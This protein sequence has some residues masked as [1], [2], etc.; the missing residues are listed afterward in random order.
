MTSI[1]W[2][3]TLVTFTIFS[4]KQKKKN[5]KLIKLKVKVRNKVKIIFERGEKIS[6][7][8]VKEIRE[9]L[10]HTKPCH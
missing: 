8:E 1:L 5:L 3:Q 4:K 9:L 7:Q 6:D 10:A 2:S